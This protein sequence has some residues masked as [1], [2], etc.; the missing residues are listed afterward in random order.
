[1][2]RLSRLKCDIVEEQ[3]LGYFP[4]KNMIA[5]VWDYGGLEVEKSLNWKKMRKKKKPKNIF[6]MSIMIMLQLLE[7]RWN[8]LRVF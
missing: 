4:P 6:G 7:T 2:H 5:C 3:I 8:F 1:M